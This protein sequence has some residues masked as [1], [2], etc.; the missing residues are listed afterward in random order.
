MKQ[1][2]V[3]GLF[4]LFSLIPVAAQANHHVS[5][6]ATAVQIAEE[7]GMQADREFKA[8]MASM[9]KNMMNMKSTG[10]ADVDF[11]RS[12]IPHH[13]AAIDMAKVE[14]KYGRDPEMKKLAD[15]IIKAQE[16]EIAMMKAWLKGKG[17]E[18]Q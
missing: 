16:N 3:L 5:G 14:L 15:D 4:M 18:M 6:D 9:H 2:L 17:Q 13:Q 7:S 10:N 8:A 1:N 12:M 11:A